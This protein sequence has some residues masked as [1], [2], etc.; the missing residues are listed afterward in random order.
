MLERSRKS[1]NLF[2]K[3]FAPGVEKRPATGPDG[4]ESTMGKL[5]VDKWLAESKEWFTI[6]DHKCC[7]GQVRLGLALL[8]GQL[9]NL[10]IGIEND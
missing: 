1:Q 2:L 10:P 9:L 6:D 3:L 4:K 8:H 5:W 7:A